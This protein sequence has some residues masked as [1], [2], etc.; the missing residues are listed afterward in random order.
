M[1]GQV[2]SSQSSESFEYMLLEGD[3]YE[4][5]PQSRCYILSGRSPDEIYQLVVLRKEKPKIPSGL[6]RELEDILH[7]CFK[8]D[9]RDRPLMK[10]IL[11]AFERCIN[12]HS[13]SDAD[14][15]KAEKISHFNDTNWALLKDQVQVG[16]AVCPR[17]ARNLC[18][19]ES[20]ENPISEGIIVVKGSDDYLLVRVHGMPIHNPLR[21]H[22][23]T[24]ERVAYGFVAGDWVRASD[25]DKKCSLVGIL[26]PK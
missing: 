4:L 23:S 11:R 16:D 10:D 12:V 15:Q 25:E 19:S 3:P 18:N 21:V 17:K 8:Y 7:G 5:R 9:F 24:V 26:Q 6:P 14:D 1:A 20:T 13:E 22:Y 2:A